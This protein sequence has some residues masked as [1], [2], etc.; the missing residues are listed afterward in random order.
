[1]AQDS[2]LPA[3]YAAASGFRPGT[4]PTRSAILARK[5]L[6]SNQRTTLIVTSV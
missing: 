6:D 2:N 1:M 3:T 5:V 4:L